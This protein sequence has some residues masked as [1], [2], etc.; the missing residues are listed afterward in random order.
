MKQF[1]FATAVLM[2]TIVGVGMFSL[3][4][5]GA[6]SG[7][8]IAAIFLFILTG[9]IV[10]V[11]LLYGEIVCRT[12]EKHRLVGYAGHYLGKWGKRIVA[13]SVI[14]GFYGSLVAYIIVGGSFLHVILGFLG[15]VPVIIFHLIF[16]TIGAIAIYFG[17]RLI[18]GL[19][20]LMSLFL[21][22]IVFLFLYLGFNQVDVNNFKTIDLR[23]IFIPYGA[24]LYS[25]AGMAAIPEIREI[26]SK[27]SKVYKTSIIIGTLIPAILYFLFMGTVVGLSGSNTSPESIIGL[28]ELLGHKAIFIGSLFG[29]LACITSFF[30]LGLSLRNTF[31]YDF[32]INKNLSW[33]LVCFVPLG[34]FIL[35]MRSFI[36]II[37]LLGAL[38]GAIEGTAIVLIYKKAKEAGKRISDYNL[39]I[40]DLLRYIII[41]IF[42]SGFI[43]TLVSMI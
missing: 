8:L 24:I 43:Y 31:Y 27:N 33:F 32:K 10:L 36:P 14:I 34:L 23:Y 11:H 16:F 2:S 7:L 22:L 5:A 26:I 40:P 9:I 19:D 25:L 39:K 28:T 6:Q 35:G 15:N 41:L 3:P 38:L 21:I 4:Y 29:F 18:A 1:L 20:F 17:L 30:V 13:S 37:I 12:K 42:I